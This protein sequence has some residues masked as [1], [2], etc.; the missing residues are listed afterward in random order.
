M[1]DLCRGLRVRV[2][3]HTGV[4]DARDVVLNATTGRTQY[5]GQPL[6]TAKAVADCGPGGMVLLSSATFAAVPAARLQR[7]GLPLNM[8]EYRF[9][10]EQ[11]PPGA[12]YQLVEGKMHPRLAVLD[13]ELRSVTQLQLG[14]LQAPVGYVSI[15]FVNV[16]G[17]ST[18]LAWDAEVAGRALQLFHTRAMELMLALRVDCL[19]GDEWPAEPAGPERRATASP[20]DRE[21]YVVEMADGLCLAAFPT[22]AAAI[23]WALRLTDSL[24][25]ADW[26]PELL[27]HELCEEVCVGGNRFPSVAA[28]T[29]AASATSTGHGTRESPRLCTAR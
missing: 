10:A 29:R 17:A 24:L 28:M 27:A 9:S 8:G 18:L 13:P 19:S 12:V 3:V 1:D 7:L 6:S 23:L 25:A 4:P 2:G 22:S 5:T 26:E 21:G 20:G 16:V 15:A 14:V 11:V